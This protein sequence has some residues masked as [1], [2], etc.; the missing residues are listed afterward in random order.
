MTSP[1]NTLRR[2]AAAASVLL[3]L[4]GIGCSSDS[5]TGGGAQNPGGDL[6]DG[7]CDPIAPEHCGFP[8]PS[9]VYLK[10][11]PT[12]MNPS[13]MSVRF[14]ANTLPA[15][16]G[17]YP[18]DPSF[19]Y[20]QDGFS[21]GQAPMTYLPG[22]TDTGLATPASIASTL[23]A[24]SPTILLDADSGE[25]VPHWVDLDYSVRHADEAAL[26]IRPAVRLKDGTRYIVAFRH[27]KD[28]TGAEIPPSPAFKALRDGTS[29][30]EASVGRRRALYK[31][32]FAKLATAGVDKKDLQIAWDYTTASKLNN[33]QWMVS[34]RDQA[35]AA[36]GDSGP[37][38][39][40]KSV[41]EAPES[42]TLRRI[43]VTM[44]TP[45]YL[46]NGDNYDAQNPDNAARLVLD[47]KGM[48][49]QNGTMDQD[50]LIIVPNSVQTAGK[51]GLM[52]NGHGLLGD[53]TEGQ[54]GYLAEMADGYHYIAFATNYFGF[55]EDDTN[56]VIDALGSRIG[57]LR[58]FFERQ[59]QGQVNQ[60]TA[61]RMMIGRIAK[62]GIKDAQGKVL[63]D[64]AWI[65]N[66][67]RVYRG[68]SQGGIMGTSYMAVSTDVTRGLV[69]EPGMPYNLLLNRSE[70]WPKFGFILGGAY[71]NDLDIQILQGLMQ[72]LWDRTEPD[73]YAPYITENMLPN[74][75]SHHI[76]MHAARGDHQVTTLAAAVIARAVKAKLIEDKQGE[77]MRDVYGLDKAPAPLQD[78]NALVEYDFPALAPEPLHNLPV[79]TGF[80]PHDCVRTLTPS[81]EQSDV[82]FRTGK[83]D[84]YCNGICD[85]GSANEEDGCDD[86]H[87]H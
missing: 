4:S 33:T 31:D 18:I 67:L 49:K 48:P 7:D 32:I 20:G 22:A 24:D 35:L 25:L 80:D 39:T 2:V 71:S 51:H 77:V 6:L 3:T 74:T 41:E 1:M 65:D 60:L 59:I 46:T 83:I 53:R 73:G 10:A 76:L 61:M 26:M 23:G 66:T 62:D 9:N 63:L 54:G 64:P 55:A 78:E 87:C 82:F 13:G 85:C 84:W 75:P 14:G 50:V 56:L 42:H 21:P 81:Y 8:F 79:T 45:L 5:G 29:S 52:Q 16:L 28:E 69:G 72:M 57:L 12:G 43:T 30:K 70:D 68:D 11:D 44:H 27:V 58:S 36:V 37:E 15:T 86:S 34:M 40:L 38:F 19:F 17:Q 47:D